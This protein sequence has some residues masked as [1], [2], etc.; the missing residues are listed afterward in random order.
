MIGVR[1]ASMSV[2]VLGKDLTLLGNPFCRLW[3]GEQQQNG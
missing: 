1:Y 3:S 2:A